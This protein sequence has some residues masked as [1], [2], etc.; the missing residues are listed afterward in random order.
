M[1]KSNASARFP[2]CTSQPHP[3]SSGPGSTT[4][5]EVA[6]SSLALSPTSPLSHPHATM[7]TTSTPPPKINTIPPF[8][9]ANLLDGVPFPDWRQQLHDDGYAVIPAI[10]RER[11]LEYRQRAF[12]WLE[13][14]GL[15]REDPSTFRQEKLPLFSRGGSE[16]PLL[17]LFGLLLDAHHKFRRAL[18]GLGGCC[19]AGN[20]TCRRGRST[21]RASRVDNTNPPALS[22]PSLTVYG[23]NSYGFGQAQWVWD[24]RTEPGVLAAFELL[25]GTEKLVCSFDGEPVRARFRIGWFEC[26]A[27][28]SFHR[29]V[30]G[31]LMLP[32][33]GPFPCVGTCARAPRL[34]PLSP[35]HTL[36][37]PPSPNQARTPPGNISTN[38]LRA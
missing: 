19:Q 5:S 32:G 25:W 24:I 16:C 18:E 12:D 29:R 14:Y 1:G 30:G 4:R 3:A 20:L 35:T 10:P 34:T 23:G 33:Q 31:S 17:R 28:Y 36:A 15:D 22:A 21:S 8:P 9:Y 37:Q 6:T 13:G 26:H 2:V 38:P 27:H 11:A 7:S